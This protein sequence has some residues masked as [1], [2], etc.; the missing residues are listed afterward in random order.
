MKEITIKFDDK[1]YKKINK[2]RIKES[3]RVRNAT[4]C[5][6]MIEAMIGAFEDD[7]KENGGKRGSNK[8]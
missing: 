5:R 7:H 6:E 8:K 1:F 2:I 3:P 4:F